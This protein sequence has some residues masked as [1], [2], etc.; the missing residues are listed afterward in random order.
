MA[1]DFPKSFLEEN[2]DYINPN[3]YKG[4]EKETWEQM[5]DIWGVEKYITYCEL[6]IFKYRSRLGK[7]PNEPI[8]RDLKKIEWYENKIKDLR[9]SK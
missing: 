5:V 3:H 4:G 2:Y 6:T 1:T 8:E 9:N 7:K